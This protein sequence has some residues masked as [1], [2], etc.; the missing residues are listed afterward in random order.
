M[1]VRVCVPVCMFTCVCV[2]VYVCLWVCLREPVCM[3]AC[4]CVYVCV[5]VLYVTV[6][7]TGVVRQTLGP[8]SLSLCNVEPV[9]PPS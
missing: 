4:A 5:A 6:S 7:T 9:S 8:H 2:Y 3:S 1:S